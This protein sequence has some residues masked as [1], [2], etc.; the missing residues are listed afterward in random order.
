M[1]LEECFEL[2]R[3]GKT[4]FPQDYDYE[5]IFEEVREICLEKKMQ[6][7]DKNKEID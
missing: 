4:K 2:I 1:P 3:T 5:E 6:E 7:N